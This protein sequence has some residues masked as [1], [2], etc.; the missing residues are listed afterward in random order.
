MF[1]LFKKKK[2]LTRK[3]RTENILKKE[4][5]KI[6]F[7]LPNIEPEEETILRN[8]KEIAER[9]S[10][11][12]ITNML[13]FNNITSEEANSYLKKHKLWEATT[14]DEKSF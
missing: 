12:A 9:V 5:I 13:A 14:E 1:N 4:G 7:N 8:P 3:E 6:N 10:V 2:E 11:L